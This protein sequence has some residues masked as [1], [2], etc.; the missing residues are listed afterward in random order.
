M[1]T[2]D[3]TRTPMMVV[4]GMHRSGTSLCSNMLAALGA[5]MADAPGAT[6]DNA[7]GHWERPFVC[8]LNDR[9]FDL[10][11]RGWFDSAHLLAMPEL[12]L[13]DPRVI[14][15]RRDAAAWLRP[16]LR[17]P[18]L[19][20]LKDPR[21]TRLLPFWQTVFTEAGA[22]PR[23]VMCLREPAQVTRSIVARDGLP[24]A[25]AEYRWLTYNAAAIGG[26]DTAAICIVPYEDWFS[27][28]DET[29][30]R[31]ATHAGLPMP[32][33]RLPRAVIDP[34]LRHDAA[35]AARPMARRLHRQMLRCVELNRF[36]ADLRAFAAMLTGFEHQL[37][38]LLA[39]MEVLRVSVADQSRVIGDL[40]ALINQL[41]PARAA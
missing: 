39:D 38:P 28:P 14:A 26:V 36:D 33:T 2:E 19:F 18:Q 22:T 40:N 5:D 12:W 30:E 35:A 10:Y 29:T 34:T 4:L 1:P 41:R 20:G 32:A 17:G 21:V 8:H 13:S 3:P 11:G 6:P 27:R 23:Y 31:L 15:L 37:Q 16:R 7:R 25:Q 9:I 24:A